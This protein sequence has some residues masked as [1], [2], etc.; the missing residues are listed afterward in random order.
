MAFIRLKKKRKG[1]E[2]KNNWAL[3]PILLGTSEQNDQRQM[4]QV[5]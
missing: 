3:S 2:K 1:K 4:T 5:F